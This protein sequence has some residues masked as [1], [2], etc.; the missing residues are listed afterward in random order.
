MT[1]R[2]VTSFDVFDTLLVRAVQP[3]A[4]VFQLVA[5][6]LA[7]MGHPIDPAAFRRARGDA[8]QALV[9]EHGGAD[10]PVT[11]EDIAVRLCEDLGWD[12]ALTVLLIE[13]ELAVETDVLRPSPPG[14]ALLRAARRRG[15]A[16][17][18]TSDMYVPAAFVERVLRAHGLWEDGDR[19]YVSAEQAASKHSGRLFDVVAA[20][21]GVPAHA[22]THVGDS[23]TGDVRGARRRGLRAVHLPAA[24]P[25]RYE[26]LLADR[27][28]AAGGLA[29]ALAGAA[30]LARLDDDPPTP[31]ERALVELVT[32]VAAPALLAFVSW[33]LQQARR[34]DIHQVLFVARD[35]QVLADLARRLDPDLHVRYVYGGR[36]PWCLAAAGEGAVD[37]SWV[38]DRTASL[39]VR[40]VLDRLGLDPA[41]VAGLGPLTA[42]H[43]PLAPVELRRLHALLA[44][45]ENRAPVAVAAAER[46]ELAVD[47][48]RQEGLL[49]TQPAA[50]VDVGW[51]GTVYRAFRR[52]VAG[53]GCPPPLG[54]YLDLVAPVDGCASFLS[55][56]AVQR[57]LLRLL[58]G[59]VTLLETF[60]AADHGTVLGYER[61]GTG[62]VPV[63]A[64]TP[65]LDADWV[66]RLRGL[67][68]RT[69][70]A[71]V[72]ADLPAGTP[73]LQHAV[74]DVLSA[75][76]TRPTRHEAEALGRVRFEDGMGRRAVM[77]PLAAPYG[78]HD[79]AR[80]LTTLHGARRHRHEWQAGSLA[81][82]PHGLREPLAMTAAARRSLWRLLRSR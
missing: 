24:A 80:S 35:G 44:R 65:R 77:R 64:D 5:Y 26:R 12:R 2:G 47:Y 66:A 60:T 51:S 3:P 38:W 9:A 1:G 8:E 81:R 63:L 58:G 48:L 15:Q 57:R 73:A 56:P 4:T 62:I 46:R 13:S 74:V 29:G 76:W 71:L 25:T 30:R 50:L 14:A 69:G 21:E 23:R 36:M 39:S 54:L 78:A 33:C 19:C 41:Q 59:A 75:L 6:R 32:G 43:E 55:E 72:D 7:R 70:E 11:L 45:P 42:W 31:G 82:T 27:E 28:P 49:G 79:L 22:L 17:V 10:A 34:Q 20:A 37:E 61:R 68:A 52:L 18:F 67:L 53:E 16:I 40:D